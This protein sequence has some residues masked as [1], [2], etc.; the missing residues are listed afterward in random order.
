[1]LAVARLELRIPADVDERE[2]EADLGL[3]IANNLDGACTEVA[4]GSV[5]QGDA[6]GYG[7]K[8]LVVVASETRRTASP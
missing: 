8:P 1:M 2:L 7:Y 4:I 5:V 6:R 3:H